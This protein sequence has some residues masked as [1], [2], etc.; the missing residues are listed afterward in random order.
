MFYNS[1]QRSIEQSQRKLLDLSNQISTNKRVIDASDDPLGKAKILNYR[2]SLSALDQYPR[3]LSTARTWLS[4]TDSALQDVV[5][6]IQSAKTLALQQATGSASAQSRLA[7]VDEVEGFIRSLIQVGNTRVGNQ[8][9]FGG[10]STQIKPFNDDG[11][12]NGNSGIISAEIGQGIYEK[13]NLPGSSFLTMDLNPNIAVPSSTT[14]LLDVSSHGYATGS[15]AALDLKIISS[16]TNNTTYDLEL[17]LGADGMTRV[18]VTTDGTANRDELGQALRDAINQDLTAKRYVTASYTDWDPLSPDTTGILTLTAKTAGIEA[19]DYKA[20][21]VIAPFSDDS[22]LQFSGALSKVDSGFAIV[23]GLNSDLVFTE[24]EGAT[25]LTADIITDGGPLAP[26]KTIFSGEEVAQRL[27]KAL[28]AKSGKGYSYTVT[29][30]PEVN[31]FEIVNDQENGGSV[32]FLWDQAGSTISKA[33]GFDPA[34]PSSSLPPGSHEVSDSQVEFYVLA[35]QNDEFEITVDGVT[36]PVTLTEG[37]YTAAALAQHLQSQING[38]AG[39]PGVTVNYSGTRGGLFS[40]VSQSTGDGSSIRLT[41]GT[42]DFLRTVGLQRSEYVDGTDSVRLE[43]LNRGQ[44]I[45]LDDLY[46][47]DR[48]GNQHSYYDLNNAGLQ[49]IQDVIDIINKEKVVIGTSNQNL[50]ITEDPDGSEGGPSTISITLTPAVYN[51]ADLGLLAADIQN[52]L[53]A[54]SVH[55]RTYTVNWDAGER[56]FSITGSGDFDIPWSNQRA[57]ASTLGFGPDDS[58]STTYTGDYWNNI[59]ATINRA[60]NGI[61]LVDANP[62][63]SQIQPLRVFDTATARDLGVYSEDHLITINS[64]NNFIYYEIDDGN[65]ATPV[66]SGSVFRATLKPGTYNGNQMVDELKS[67]LEHAVD[68]DGNVTPVTFSGIRFDPAL[69]RMIIDGAS[70][71]VHFYWSAK[72]P[73]GVVSSA[74]SGLGF[75]QESPGYQTG[76]FTAVQPAGT[77]GRFGNIEGSDL[78]PLVKGYTPVTQLYAGSDIHLD[79]IKITNGKKSAVIDLSDARNVQD[80]IDRINGAGLDVAASLS[81]DGTS[82][83]VYSLNQATVPVVEND[84]TG[85]TAS[86]LGLKGGNDV[87]GALRDFKQALLSNDSDALERIVANLQAALDHVQDYV[88]ETG[89]RTKNLDEVESYLSNFSLD[90]KGLL[91]E[92]EDVDI[93]EAITRYT[94]QQQVL[95]AILKASAQIMQIS[96]L[97]FLE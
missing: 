86:L 77:E 1:M 90:V 20:S 83:Q 25:L 68:S 37:A 4:S 35:G 31:R 32:Q 76:P 55:G 53:T 13:Y 70:E 49:T 36:A 24:D 19:N 78:K 63:A 56:R 43:D 21:S 84:G 30:D 7:V 18:S 51:Q 61:Q 58:G 15:K 71:G 39:M 60:G 3:N 11:S 29:Y 85:D 34:S 6:T 28:E 2:E 94:S 69:Q 72:G 88:G 87:L 91:S 50:E 92:T 9:I 44:G 23:D 33:L 93:T 52:K 67:A 38:I 73:D 59:V 16:P 65:P 82:L 26:G 14:G 79:N 42:N 10:T 12:Y 64:S 40:I 5:D 22:V 48:A 27:E 45:R 57:I 81:R 75:T 80:I 46:L 47:M 89:S 8:Y 41:E 17:D 95:E 96:L 97:D 54:N 62:T 66:G 74:A